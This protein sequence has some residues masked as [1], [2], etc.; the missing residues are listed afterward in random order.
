M[1]R[2]RFVP[3]RTFT[4]WFRRDRIQAAA[5]LVAS[6]AVFNLKAVAQDTDRAVA[7][8][9]NEKIS[10]REFRIRYELSPHL[11]PDQQNVDSTKKDLLYS[12]IAEKLLALQARKLGYA[13]TDFYRESVRQI[14][15]LY[16][17]DALYKKVIASR[18]E[19]TRSDIQKALDRY[20][21]TLHVRIISAGDSSTIFGYYNRLRSG[22]PFD[23]IE[24]Y[25]NPVEYN[26]N[27]GPINIT[28]GQMADDYVEDT[29]YSLKPGLF[30][31][32]VRTE[33]GWF[34]FRL[35][36]V[37][38]RVPPNVADP[39]YNK[40][41]VEVIRMRKSRE[42]GIKYLDNFYR[43]KHA[44]VDSSLFWSLAE[45]VSSIL[46]VKERNKNF[47]EGGYLYLSEGDIM[48]IGAGFGDGTLD[49]DIVH[50]ENH[51]VSL[52]EYLYSLLV[53]PYLV[54]DPSLRA[55]AYYLM[56]NINKYIQ[57]KFLSEEGMNLGLQH[58]PDVREDVNIWGDDYLAKMLKNTFRDS[59]QV[60]DKEVH[61]YYMNSKEHE[62]VDILE[63]LNDNVDTIASVLKRI[64]KGEDF[65]ALAREYTQRSWTRANGGE[66]GYFPVDSFGVIGKMAV[67]LRMNEVYGP[68]KTD[69]GF[70]II[71]LIGRKLQNKQREQVR[72][73]E[74]LTHSLDTVETVFRK[75]HAGDDFA[76]LARK[77][78]ER[79]WTKRDS[80]AFGYFSVYSFGDIGRVA[81]KM[82][83]GQIYGPIKTDSGYSVIELIGRRYD[84][85]RTE[86]D[87]EAEKSEVR[88]ELLGKK[89]NEKFFKYI[90]ELAGK[91]KYS[92]N[93]KNLEAVKVVN[94]PMFTYKY[95]GFGGRITALPYLGPWY[96]WVN[97]MGK[98][99]EPIP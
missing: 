29:L 85:T 63:I 9:G 65:R 39:N 38:Y 83:P 3:R 93:E 16:V 71:K 33:G 36:G 47:G 18:V 61:D 91:Y 34:I 67:G 88:Q 25:S 77:Y 46:T 35:V 49:K 86:K 97:Y 79:S 92:I 75:I 24:K 62:E 32:P 1:K 10:E 95:I 5:V 54:K 27:G 4:A 13:S 90:A 78:T 41:I 99:S 96:G 12:I 50:I 82:K 26:S 42:I 98:K 53:Y 51:P 81:S 8:V 21:Q 14:R 15:N 28:Y 72:V 68:F 59:V 43:D 94:V 19:I 37:D 22:A 80:G 60:T 20:S 66:F 30:S 44:V 73:R 57:Y 84:T 55:T 89:F 58:K 7:T 70:S 17:R 48:R 74:I 64:E 23:S 11:S 52:K 6:L 56:Q 31:S 87:F 45:K 2:F 69:S 40:S 76:A